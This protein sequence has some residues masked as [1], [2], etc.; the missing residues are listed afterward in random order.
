[1]P[2]KGRGIRPSGV[3]VINGCELPNSGAG[4][5]TRVLWKG[6][7]VLLPPESALYLSVPPN[8]GC[9]SLHRITIST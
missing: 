2:A 4:N 6:Q 1:M 5:K 8:G 7:Q 9:K 3:G